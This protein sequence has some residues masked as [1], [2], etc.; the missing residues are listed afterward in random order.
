MWTPDIYS[1]EARAL[2]SAVNGSVACRPPPR[3]LQGLAIQQPGPERHLACPR[4]RSL[5]PRSLHG[6]LLINS[7]IIY[8]YTRG[9]TMRPIAC[10]QGSPSLICTRPRTT[11]QTGRPLT[12][13]PCHGEGLFLLW[14]LLTSMTVS[15]SISITVTSPSEPRRIAPFL[16]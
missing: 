9:V 11:V 1:I 14:S 8:H 10:P 3:P 5:A 13:Q 4:S 15:L 6:Y 16:G 12:F 2:P 7:L